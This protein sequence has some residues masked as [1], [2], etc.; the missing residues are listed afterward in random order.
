M[1]YKAV[2]QRRVFSSPRIQYLPICSPLL[3]LTAINLYYLGS[4]DTTQLSNYLWALGVCKCVFVC[5]V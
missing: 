5:G 2:T 1:Y 4:K 3:A